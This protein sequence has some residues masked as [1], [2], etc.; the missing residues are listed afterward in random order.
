[1]VRKFQS[2]FF[3]YK[4][5]TNGPIS[6]NFGLEEAKLLGLK[7]NMSKY[8]VRPIPAAQRVFKSEG[9]VHTKVCFLLIKRLLMIGF[10]KTLD[11]KKQNY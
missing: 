9:S 8:Y 10:P 3:A 5:L 11:H 4:M 2:S 1:M 7:L 6:I